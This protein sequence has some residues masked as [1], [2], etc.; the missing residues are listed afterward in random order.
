MSE[1]IPIVKPTT[2]PLIAQL[3][4]EHEAKTT[5]AAP[6]SANTYPS[7][8]IDLPSEGYFYSSGSPLSTG[9][10][11]IKY[12]TAKEEDI[13]TSANLLKKN[14]ALERLLEALVVTPGVKLD[15][16]LVCD[17]NAVYIQARILAYGS[18][19]DVRIKCPACGDESVQR[20]NLSSLKFKEIDFSKFSKGQNSFEYTLPTSKKVVTFK[21]LN[22]QDEDAINAELKSLA[23]LKSEVTADR[24]TRLK[25]IITAIDGNSETA[26]IRKSVDEL[27]AKDALAL[28]QHIAEVTPDLNL[29]FTFVCP[30]CGHQEEMMIPIG[31]NFFW[32]DSRV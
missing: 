21:L 14:V 10:L 5:V 28:R 17:K 32:P 20:I 26:H 3:R 1:N 31:V 7:E 24:T 19:Y 25:H 23:K 18:D 27:L 29:T 11:E 8:T 22:G 15:D 30:S 9:K 4:Q 2:D 12:M 16:L 13:L 6:K